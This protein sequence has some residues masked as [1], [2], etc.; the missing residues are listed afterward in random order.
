MSGS[1]S[2]G[3][4]QVLIIRHGEKLGS[5]N[6]EA[7][8]GPNLSPRGSAR[9]FALPSLFVPGTPQIDCALAAA[10][11]TDDRSR[12]S[13][14]TAVGSVTGTYGQ[15]SIEGTAPRFPMPAFVFATQ[16]S[17][18]SN[19]PVETVSPLLAAFDLP[20]DASHSD[21]DYGKVA[22]DILTHPKYAGAVVLVCWHHGKI[23]AL[24]GALRVSQPPS[25]P[26]TVFDRVWQLIYSGGTPSLANLPQLLLYGDSTT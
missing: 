22:Q 5:A 1:R 24:A 11:G 21:D 3:A 10:N 13:S 7:E 25:W 14:G 8:G 2:S 17:H 9:A 6:N 18:R 23:Q 20:L 26:G 4:S 19:R 12:S 15:V 16:A